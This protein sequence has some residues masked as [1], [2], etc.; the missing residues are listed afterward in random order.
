MK[1]NILIAGVTVAL[2]TSFAAYAWACPWIATAST[3]VQGGA[4]GVHCHDTQ[5]ACYPDA[6][7]TPCEYCDS[8]YALNGSCNDVRT[9]GNALTCEEDPTPWYR[10]PVTNPDLYWYNCESGNTCVQQQGGTFQKVIATYGCG[11]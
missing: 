5:G 4:L 11:G 6:Q 2:A 9:G 3:Y 10:F 8:D 7:N 1:R